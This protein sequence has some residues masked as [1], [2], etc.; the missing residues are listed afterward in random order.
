MTE[1][2]KLEARAKGSDGPLSPFK[3]SISEPTAE[4]TG[5]FGCFMDCPLLGFEQHKVFGVDADQAMALALWLV[6]DQLKHHGYVLVGDEGEHV[7]L[8]IDPD[9]MVPGQ[10]SANPKPE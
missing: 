10:A 6:E 7:Q 9:A 1:P 2:Y 8:P 5:E 3:L 4:D